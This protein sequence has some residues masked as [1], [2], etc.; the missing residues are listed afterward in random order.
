[1]LK[2]KLKKLKKLGID[3][4]EGTVESEIMHEEVGLII[5]RNIISQLKL[6]KR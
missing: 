5:G 6:E 2:K 3:V 1:M 4:G